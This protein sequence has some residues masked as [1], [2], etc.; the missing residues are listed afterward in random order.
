M[1]LRNGLVLALGVLTAS[2]LCGC[3]AYIPPAVTTDGLLAIKKGMT[4]AEV[5]NL[6]GPPLCVIEVDTADLTE[7]DA[8]IASGLLR[9]CKQSPKTPTSVPLRLR[10]AAEL[11]L[12][13]AEPRETLFTDPAIYVHLSNG[14]VTSVYIKKDDLG[15]CCMEGQPNS[16]FYWVGSREVLRELVGR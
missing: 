7:E 11:S 13:Y 4:Y 15:I 5:E 8:A 3:R 10:Q 1:R 2:A 14:A 16:P 6:I 9:D 12:S